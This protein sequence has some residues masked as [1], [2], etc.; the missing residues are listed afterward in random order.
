MEG[1]NQNV[2]QILIIYYDQH[3]TSVSMFTDGQER[4][5]KEIK[6][7]KERDEKKG[8][9]SNGIVSRCF[10][11]TISVLLWKRIATYIKNVLQHCTEGQLPLH[12]DLIGVCVCH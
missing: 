6:R 9:Y 8:E 1:S 5:I 12:V 7:D 2:Q 4:I 10:D 3:H 11:D